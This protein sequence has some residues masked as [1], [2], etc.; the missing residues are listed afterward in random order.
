MHSSTRK[1]Q[2]VQETEEAGTAP[3]YAISS[4]SNPAARF[5]VRSH[6]HQSNCRIRRCYTARRS[7]GGDGDR[8][9]SRAFIHLLRCGS[10]AVPQRDIQP[11]W[12]AGT[13]KRGADLV[14]GCESAI[15]DASSSAYS[16][17]GFWCPLI[18]VPLAQDKA[19]VGSACQG[20][21]PAAARLKARG[22]MSDKAAPMSTAS[23]AVLGE[24]RP[25][26]SCPAHACMHC[27]PHIE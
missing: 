10:R 19:S 1:G 15:V 17:A 21:A 16:V 12:D 26:G 9:R 11:S 22:R 6:S 14:T 25:A 5:S 18:L 24:A 8:Q 23:R 2:L 7:L 13:E 20:Q 27:C 4:H 3:P